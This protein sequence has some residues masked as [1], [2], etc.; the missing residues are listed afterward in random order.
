MEFGRVFSVNFSALVGMLVSTA[1][2]WNTLR[3]PLVFVPLIFGCHGHTTLPTVPTS[4][5]KF[6]CSL[7]GYVRKTT[8]AADHIINPEYHD[9]QTNYFCRVNQVVQ[10]VKTDHNPQ[11]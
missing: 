8:L 10:R 4:A 2:R 1:A 6:L 7:Q 11:Q 9:S 5:E 3:P